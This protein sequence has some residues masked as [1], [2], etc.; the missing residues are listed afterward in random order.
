MK[1]HLLTFLSIY[2]TFSSCST[3]ETLPDQPQTIKKEKISGYVQ[4][5]PFVS[6]TTILMSELNSELAQTGKV[7][8]ST[9]SNDM[10]LFEV[11]NIELNSSFVEFSS[12]G[13]YFNEVTGDI[14]SAPISLTSLSDLTD[15]SS[16]NVNVLTHLEKKRVETLLK[17][18][19][20]FS[21]AKDQAKQEVLSIFSA[22][23]DSSA[24]F[25]D[26][27][28]SKNN[29]EGGVL[30]AISVIL[31]GNR[32]VGELTELL[33]KIQND[34]APD[35]KLNDNATINALRVST[36]EIDLP[37]VRQNIESR[38]KDLNITSP[39]PDFEKHISKFLNL[40]NLNI[41]VEGEGTV[42]EEIQSNP[43]GRE[44]LN[45]TTVKLTPLPAEGWVF[46][47]WA[48]DLT[49]NEIPQTILIDQ[50]KNVTAKFVRK[51]YALNITIEGEG[52][53]VEEIVSSPNGREYPFQTVVKLT[54]IPAEGSVFNR[55]EGDLSGNEFP[56]TI[57]VEKEKNITV[58]FKR[59]VFRLAENGVT[60]IC[61]GVKAGDKGVVNG[62]E[63]EAVDN[64]LLRKRRDENKDLT[65]LCTSIV[66]DMEGLF[67]GMSQFN[68]Q[69]QN[70]DVSKVTTMKEM[71]QS[72]QFNQPIGIW[73]V[74]NVVDMSSMFDGAAFNQPLNNWDVSNVINMGSMFRS[75]I[76]F[77]QPIDKWNVSKVTDM[78][79]MFYY[80]PFNQSLNTWN[81]SSVLNMRSM[82]NGS[83]FNQPIDYWDVSSV[84]NMSYMFFESIF[85]QPIG[86]WDVSSV[87]D[88]SG[89][90]EG[91]R[92]NLP[93]E[94]WDTQN[95]KTMRLMFSKSTFNKPI[96]DWNVEN[97]TDMFEMFSFSMFN[98]DI[99]KWC[100]EN[101]NFR[102]EMFSFDSPL[103][104]AY[105]PKWGTCPD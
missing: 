95:I 43:S 70:W 101:I 1:K 40:N 85:N 60:C 26:F 14:S 17:E 78:S 64:Q 50:E 21:E 59:P 90:F 69:I 96:G 61:E 73:N 42:R 20:S 38:N 99:S 7:F 49:G 8:T 35:G 5:G 41:T 74:G 105:E 57:T 10:G 45:G 92:F 77:N 29:E 56:I 89:M 62:V 30:L 100:V 79:W 11:N 65:K 97:V 18:G 24:D 51:N 4:K 46:D 83:K 82:F 93:L 71:F 47:G 58:I 37:K 67:R 66:T 31:Q 22:I 72:T 48:G 32:S 39:V 2:L 63:Y 87:F 104:P 6:G 86:V 53:V 68:Q 75:N 19:K 12:S 52:T 98:Q 33:S 44:Y 76:K 27:D 13:F 91:S 28:I 34:L 88:T 94:N 9:I 54:P 102:P 3:D 81:V 23:L 55:W 25:E 16:I 103:V 84:E 80:S 36:F 15:K